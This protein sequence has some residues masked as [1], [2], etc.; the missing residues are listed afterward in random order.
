MMYNKRA[1]RIVTYTFLFKQSKKIRVQIIFWAI[2]AAA[3]L[4]AGYF[5]AVQTETALILLG[6]IA[7]I[8]LF[9]AFPRTCLY[10]VIFLPVIGELV[11]IPIAAENGILISDA[12]IPLFVAVW[13]IKKFTRH[14]RL[15]SSGLS[16]PFLAFCLIAAVSLLQT[17]LL[18]RPSEV[19]LSSYYLI[20]LISYVLL[21]LITVDSVKNESQAKKIIACIFSAAVIIAVI[22]FVQLAVY[23]DLSKLEQLGWDPHMGRLVSTWLDP[24]FVGG[25][26]AFIICV[27]VGIILYHSKPSVK[28]A[29]AV[30]A[31][32]LGT[33]LFL[34]YSRSAYLAVAAGIIVIGLLRSR[35]LIIA[36]VVLLIAGI[37]IFPR[38]AER[39]T[40]L[41][42]TATAIV[43]D[44]SENPDATARLRIKSWEQTWDLV[45]ERPILGSGFNALRYVKYSEGFVEDPQIHSASGSDSS[46]LTILATT[47]II[48]LAVFTWF[49]AQ[50][51]RLAYRGWMPHGLIRAGSSREKLPSV[52]S[53]FSLGML[54]GLSSLTVHS[55]FVNSLLFPQILIPVII[56]VGI[57]QWR[58]I[59]RR[60]NINGERIKIQPD[61]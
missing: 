1:K 21:C 16:R 33:A 30:L 25:Y 55:L 45:Y 40:D 3:S 54:A 15:P 17:F 18:V 53:G 57:L 13:I 39:L 38:A 47:G 43:F 10:F 26:L 9:Y 42:H 36:S 29:L 7:L 4:A 61:I 41:T 44:T 59:Q 35:A 19:L 11:R 31:V 24:N 14:E 51:F 37:A 8:W 2:S 58:I 12:V 60:I 32:V 6:L 20:R 22:G 5:L 23:P 46:L 48:G 28:I 49:Y 50:F 52:F 56:S 27:M 34:T